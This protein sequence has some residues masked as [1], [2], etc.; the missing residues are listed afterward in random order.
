[1]A[2]ERKLGTKRTFNEG[3][4]E[5]FFFAV[6]NG[7]V[8]GSSLSQT[9]G[10]N[11]GL[12][13]NTKENVNNIRLETGTGAIYTYLSADTTLYVSSSS[14][15]DT[16]TLVVIGLDDTY[17]AVTRIV[18]LNGQTPVVLS[19]DIF[20]VFLVV[21]ISSPLVV[22]IGN[23]YLSSDNTDI[24]SGVPNTL[25][26]V[27]MKID[28][29]FAVGVNGTRTIAL[30]KKGYLF[31]IV[32]NSSKSADAEIFLRFRFATTSDFSLS[33][34]FQIYQNSDTVN[35]IVGTNLPAKTDMDI[36]AET[37]TANSKITSSFFLVL[38]DI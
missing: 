30:N 12:T 16:Q 26:K 9:A 1:M 2:T 4:A 37:P 3:A 24:T 11:P 25:S 31:N 27:L 32:F 22:A 23:I 36:V 14:A 7:D 33:P 29:G 38:T 13:I 17:T 8:T 10:N 15:S 18:T 34:P 21:M 35:E 20:R 6:A 28:V 5:D 19:G